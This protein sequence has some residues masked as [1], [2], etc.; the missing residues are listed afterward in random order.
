MNQELRE[1]FNEF[2]QY[3]A[4]TGIVSF[5]KSPSRKIKVGD[6]INCHSDGYIVMSVRGKTYKLHRVI[7]FMVYGE[8]PN[9]M[10]HKNQIRDDNRLCNLRNV[11]STIN[12]RNARR[13]KDNTSGVTGVNKVGKKWRVRINTHE[14]RLSLGMYDTLMEAV[15][16]RKEAEK[17]YGYSE[18]H[19]K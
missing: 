17:I 3:D 15:K 2:C 14:G 13:R 6:V 5:K 8:V 16:V 12:N 10:D 11:N 1:Y 19:G 7:W 4:K 18:N 9:I